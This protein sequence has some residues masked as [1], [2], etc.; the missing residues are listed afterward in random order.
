MRFELD[1]LFVCT[2]PDAP[3]AENLVQFGL[4]EGPPNQHAG[5]GTANR[6]FAFTNAMIELFWVNRTNEVQ[7]PTTRRT[8]LWERW[9]GRKGNASPFGI[10]L[11]P[12]D[13]RDTEPPFP[14]WEYR[15]A[16][17]PDP[18]VMHIGEAGIEE[19][20]WIY[21]SFMQRAQREQWF[22]EHPIGIREITGLTLTT[23]V[24]LRS[25]VS[26]KIVESGILRT[27]T[28]ATSLLEIEFDGNRRK[29]YIDFRP[30]LPFVFQL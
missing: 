19:P 11:R 20:M 29:E 24:P 14:A 26:Q 13:S 16:Y 30:H 1:H 6:R 15:P 25:N 5:Q 7:G 4:R 12:V 27:Q 17:L 2:D 23:P 9:S 22:I 28:G 3:E 10:C 18:L 8:L 21:L